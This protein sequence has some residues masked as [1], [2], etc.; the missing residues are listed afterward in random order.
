[1]PKFVIKSK[2]AI[3]SVLATIIILAVLLPHL[4]TKQKEV[5]PS[6]NP[7]SDASISSGKA[8]LEINGIKYESGIVGG[9]S[10]Y[11]FM[12]KLKDEGKIN[13]T[14]KNYTGMGK[15]VDSINGVKGS[16]NQNWIYYVNGVEAQIGVSNYKIKNGD[17]VSW[18]YE[19]PNY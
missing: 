6:P 11:D 7:A 17:I 1:M 4:N 9:M 15:F 5:S 12:S 3:L 8:V 14:E 13:F 16:G 10:V 18:K 19:K 2:I